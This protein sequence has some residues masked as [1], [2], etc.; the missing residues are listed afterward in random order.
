MLFAGRLPGSRGIRRPLRPHGLPS[1]TSTVVGERLRCALHFR[2]IDGAGHF[3][4]PDGEPVTDLVQPTYPAEERYGVIFVYLGAGPRCRR[5]LP[6]SSARRICWPNRQA[7]F[8][9][10][11]RGTA[12]SPTAA[13]WSIC[14]R[15]TA[16]R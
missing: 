12:S 2:H 9:R 13:T 8:S 15:C 6:R 4:R 16:V 5:L 3:I 7:N 14:W 11:R 10:Q 1:K